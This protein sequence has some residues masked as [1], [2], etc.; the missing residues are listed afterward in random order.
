MQK[1]QVVV[2]VADG[3]EQQLAQ[4]NRAGFSVDGDAL[5]G[6]GRLTAENTRHVRAEGAEKGQL[7]RDQQILLS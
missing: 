2:Q 4:G 3:L 5:P 6:W 7:I 1:R